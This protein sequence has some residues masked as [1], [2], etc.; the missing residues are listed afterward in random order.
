MD[1]WKKSGMKNDKELKALYSIIF[2]LPDLFLWFFIPMKDQA[3]NGDCN[4]ERPSGM[5]SMGAKGAHDSWVS[6][7]GMGT[8]EV[9]YGEFIVV[10]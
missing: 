5:L 4:E 3:E 9:P 7:R 1:V 8:S 2:R 6:L 10:L